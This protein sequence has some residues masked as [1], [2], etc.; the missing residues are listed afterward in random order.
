MTALMLTLIAAG[1]FLIVRSSMINDSYEKLLEEEDYTPE[2]KIT[3]KKNENVSRIYWCTALAIYLAW[4]F[5]SGDW[6]I[7]WVIWPVAG[8]MYGAVTAAVDI[9]RKKNK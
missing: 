7:T 6:Q 9:K 4:S 3:N 5:I 2:K 8:I 1:V